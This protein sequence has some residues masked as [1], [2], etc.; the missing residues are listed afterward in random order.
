MKAGLW[1]NR[2]ILSCE[3]STFS[4]GITVTTGGTV[5]MPG[6]LLL[7]MEVAGLALH[8]LL[9]WNPTDFPIVP[10]CSLLPCFLKTVST[11]VFL[12]TLELRVV[13][14]TMQTGYD[15]GRFARVRFPAFSSTETMTQSLGFEDCSAG[16]AGFRRSIF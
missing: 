15:L 5:D 7:K 1:T 12:V 10:L 16:L 14:P 9:L 11:A 8:H 6:V 3:S 4:L 2:R 13:T